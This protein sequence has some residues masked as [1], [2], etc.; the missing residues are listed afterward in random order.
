[1]RLKKIQIC[2]LVWVSCFTLVTFPFLGAVQNVTQTF[3]QGLFIL[4][5]LGLLSF[6]LGPLLL[7]FVT[8]LQIIEYQNSFVLEL[9]VISVSCFIGG[10][11]QWFIILPRIINKYW[12]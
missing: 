1:M 8:T 5:L 12:N 7:Y 9:I 3:E 11:A 2:K 4:V 6:P 10:Y